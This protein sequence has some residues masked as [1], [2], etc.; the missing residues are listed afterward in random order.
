MGP[1]CSQDESEGQWPQKMYLVFCFS[2]NDMNALVWY[3][4]YECAQLIHGTDSHMTYKTLKHAA[5]MQIL[6][7]ITIDS[8][9]LVLLDV[10]WTTDM[11]I[12]KQEFL[13]GSKSP[14]FFR[15]HRFCFIA[16]FSNFDHSFK[17]KDSC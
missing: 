16:E 5:C 8:F 1:N 9:Q 2:P 3:E 10:R 17:S 6:E 13:V 15:N 12:K 11:R 7:M 14:K 4:C